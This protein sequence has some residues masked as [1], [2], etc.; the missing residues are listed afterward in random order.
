MKIASLFGVSL[1][2]F[3]LVISS[4]ELTGQDKSWTTDVS[5]A[6]KIA[7]LKGA[8]VNMVDINNDNYPDMFVQEELG[9][10]LSTRARNMK[11]YLNQQ[12]P[13][14]NFKG[15]RIFVDVTEQSG[16]WVHPTIPDSSRVIDI[17]LMAD[18][19]NDGNIDLVTGPYYDRLENFKFPDDRCEV[20]L[21]DGKGHFTLV[22]NN[23]L[24]ELGLLNCAGFT[25]FDYDLDGVL[26]LYIATWFKDKNLNYTQG[27]NLGFMPDY[28][29]RGNGDG[30]FTDVSEETGISSVEFP[31]YGATAMDWNN[32]GWIDILTSAYCRSGGNL[33]KNNKNGSFT[34][35][36]STIGYTSQLRGGDNGQPLCQWA[37]VPA[38]FDNDGDI[39]LLQAFVHGGVDPSE[40]HST[41]SVNQGEATGYKLKWDLTR[42]QRKNPQSTHLGDM[43]AAWFD[44][45][46]DGW[47]D[48]AYGENVYVPAT[49]RVFMFHQN[50]T[51]HSFEDMT[52]AIGMLS[53]KPC[54]ITRPNDY[55]LDGDE[56]M[57]I[58]WGSGLALLRNN[59]GR[60]NNNVEV[61]LIA[62]A[63]VNHDCI[64][65]RITVYAGGMAQIRDVLTGQGHFGAQ[66]PLEKII[67]IGQST[68]I[69]S[70]VIHWPHETLANTVVVNPP[71]NRFLI[72]GQEGIKGIIQG[73]GEESVVD[74]E[75]LSLVPNP[76][77]DLVHLIIPESAHT[78]GTITLT[79]VL[80]ETVLI[81]PLPPQTFDMVL[82][83]STVAEGMYMMIV[84]LNNGSIFSKS[85][86]KR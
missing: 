9:A 1:L 11:I 24:H 70:I 7:G 78:G 49:D 72:I 37:V 25:F 46:N 48:C 59:V 68:K 30:T 34:D 86:I 52:E 4:N 17:A 22:K 76:A 10:K 84:R 44:F 12:D 75:S 60:S 57:M 83:L 40:G 56:D 71:I 51:S 66:Q 18:L 31:M 74:K 79:D 61:K 45:D 73:V 65:A 53:Y 39:D 28:L 43:D 26:D 19:N 5:V 80:G 2:S 21:G 41:I 3:L 23:G 27:N 8:R 20:M 85:F 42:L 67:G 50:P 38:D 32:D 54:Y 47:Q 69:D 82:P 14:S 36:A 58:G 16:V 33:W 55:D 64:G 6:T 63:E 15:D 81:T 29:L 62:P 13:N 77:K 35:V